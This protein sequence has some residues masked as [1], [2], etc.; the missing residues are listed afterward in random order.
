MMTK[1]EDATR[2]DME[3][4]VLGGLVGLGYAISSAFDKNKPAPPTPSKGE[5]AP[6][7]YLAPMNIGNFTNGPTV[8]GFV[9]AA[10]GPDTNPLTTRTKGASALGFAPELDMMY[11]NP[12]GQTY[13]SEPTA[14]PQGNA[15]GYA[16]QQPPL[17]PA[18]RTK[19]LPMPEPLDTQ[20]AMVEMRSDGIEDE[21]TYVNGKYV[22]SPLSGAKI[23]A[24]EFRH[25]NMMPF[26]GG[27]VKQNIGP[28]TNTSLLD[29][30]TGAGTNQITKR[31][32]ETMFDTAKTPYGNPFGM[33]SQTNFI[34]SRINAPRNR[35]GERPFEPVRVAPGVGEG[36]GTLGKGGFQQMEVNEIMKRAM[37]TTDKLRVADNQKLTYNTPVV[38]GQHFVAMAADNAGE[39]R[40]HR[41]DTY[42]N[43]ENGERNFVTT[44]QYV[45]ETTRPTQ[46]LNYSARPETSDYRIVGPA[47]SQDFNESYTTGS[48]RTPMTQ[49]FGGAGMR[50]AKLEEYYTN[51]PDAPEADY[52]KSSI[53]IRPNERLQTQD[54]VMG[55]NV[56]QAQS[57]LVAVHYEDDARPTYRGDTI[58]NIYQSGVA[59]GYAQGA[60]SVTVWDPSDV[61]RTT[62]KEGTVDWNYLGVMQAGQGPNKLKV[63]DPEDIAKPTQKAQLSAALSWSGP[64]N[65][66]NKSFTSHDA[67][68]NMRLNPNKEQVG[69]LRKPMAG[70]GGIAIFQGEQGS[71]TSRKIE[72]DYVNDRVN[73]VNRVVEMT[74]G[75]ADIGLVKYR[76]PPQLDIGLQRNTPEMIA[77]VENNPLNQSLRKNAMHDAALLGGR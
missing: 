41:P 25:N 61:A 23:P 48:Y 30:Y 3:V 7:G 13:P 17:A 73:A 31:E 26:F 2:I 49:Q 77:A 1:T 51:N 21:P 64:G 71:Q 34:E 44:G 54:R 24:E 5:A 53:E 14:G 72:A 37:P 6:R 32:V 62:V 60:P 11:K 8:E 46:L 22:V 68:A 45:A 20:A 76:A 16:T 4:A 43:N 50:N 29:T 47:A 58:G 75:A 67:T 66:T 42:F 39:V 10:R 33:E 28:Q 12:N 70:N 69:R 38:P 40:K 9:P 65:A 15:F 57:G 59:T 35:A 19:G 18:Q 27:R 74:P 36:Y 52:G 56:A 63:Y 55:L